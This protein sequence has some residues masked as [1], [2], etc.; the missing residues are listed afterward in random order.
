MPGHQLFLWPWCLQGCY[1]HFISS[2]LTLLDSILPFHSSRG[3]AILAEW[4]SC[5]VQQVCWSPVESAVVGTGQSKVPSHRGSLY[6]V[7]YLCPSC[8]LFLPAAC[9]HGHRC[10][11]I[12]VCSSKRVVGLK[13]ANSHLK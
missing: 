1:S 3:I 12:T 11:L 4:L 7:T 9:L 2:L 13:F 6:R 10:Y 5:A 8:R